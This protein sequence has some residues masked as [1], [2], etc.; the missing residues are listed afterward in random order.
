MAFVEAPQ[1]VEEVAAV[2]KL[3]KGPCLLNIVWRGKSPDIAF[4][5]AQRMGYKVTIVPGM[6]FK[7]VI[8][9]CDATLKQMKE[10]GRHPI[11]RHRHDGARRVPPRRRRRVGC[12]ER[13]L[14]RGR[15]ERRKPAQ[16]AE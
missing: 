7:A 1:T 2:P 8:G 11:A 16:A 15:A 5:E 14:P 10:T 13:A 12:G 3:V 6:L 9:V 4:D